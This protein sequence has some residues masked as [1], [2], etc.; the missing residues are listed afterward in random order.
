MTI[1]TK[2]NLGDKVYVIFDNK[3][4]NVK[5]DGIQYVDDTVRYIWH[6]EWMGIN[7]YKYTESGCFGSKADLV[8]YVLKL[9]ELI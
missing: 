6:G 1:Q 4:I 3:I 9:P 5:I 2:Y 7:E 8:N